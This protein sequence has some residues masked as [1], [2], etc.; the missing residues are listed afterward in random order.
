MPSLTVFEGCDLVKIGLLKA[1]HQRVGLRGQLSVLRDMWSNGW[2]S[3][4]FSC[5]KGDFVRA[6]HLA[7]EN[8]ASVHVVTQVITCFDCIAILV[9]SA[10]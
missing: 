1:S 5:L 7:L 3:L 2:T 6:R 4:H 8:E 10:L 9:I